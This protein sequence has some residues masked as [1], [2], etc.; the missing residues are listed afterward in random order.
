MALAHRRQQ[1]PWVVVQILIVGHHCVSC[2][3]ALCLLGTW[4]EHTKRSLC[5]PDCH[6]CVAHH[7]GELFASS[8]DNNAAG[9]SSSS[10]ASHSSS[11]GGST[12]AGDVSSNTTSSSME[13]STSSGSSGEPSSSSGSGGSTG[14]S[15]TA[16][17]TTMGPNLSVPSY[18]Q[19]LQDSRRSS[20]PLL[21]QKIQNSEWIELSQLL[22]QAPFDAVRQVRTILQG[23]EHCCGPLPFFAAEA[24]HGWR[25]P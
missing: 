10:G 5:G 19:I 21:A 24:D 16:T 4:C 11:S 14:N 3:C 20:W 25:V 17:R 8:D 6:C 13:G 7:A 15:R 9:G 22:V 1:Q 2:W 12:A 23:L 18:I